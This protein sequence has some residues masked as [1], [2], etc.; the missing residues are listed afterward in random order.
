MTV[1]EGA[2]SSGRGAGTDSTAAAC[3]WLIEGVETL[4]AAHATKSP[5][6]KP[7]IAL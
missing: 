1:I 4:L 2:A 7:R 3:G 5:S 6:L